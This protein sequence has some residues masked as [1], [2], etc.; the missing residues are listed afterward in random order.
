VKKKRIKTPETS[1]REKT[2]Y[3]LAVFIFD[4]YSMTESII[5]DSSLFLREVLCDN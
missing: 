1:R 2:E 5:I 3:I 4:G